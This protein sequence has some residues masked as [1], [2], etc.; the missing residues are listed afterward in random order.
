[1]N[2]NEQVSAVYRSLP[3]LLTMAK[4]IKDLESNIKKQDEKISEL[5]N[6]IDERLNQRPPK[7]RLRIQYNEITESISTHFLSLDKRLKELEK[8]NGE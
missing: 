1:M 3:D 5:E 7:D 2:I 6:F 8:K 4:R